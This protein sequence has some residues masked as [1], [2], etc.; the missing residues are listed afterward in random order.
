MTSGAE[1]SEDEAVLLS[2]AFFEA[3][4]RRCGPVA[5]TLKSHYK[6]APGITQKIT[7]GNKTGIKKDK[8]VGGADSEEDGATRRST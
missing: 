5:G 2:M 1:R 4:V 8:T 3:K 6:E 7:H